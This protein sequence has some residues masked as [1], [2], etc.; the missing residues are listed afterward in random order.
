L[1]E[2]VNELGDHADRGMKGPL[3][4]LGKALLKASQSIE[5]MAETEEEE[6]TEEV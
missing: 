2:Q 5:D 4:K 3:H 1:G 6:E